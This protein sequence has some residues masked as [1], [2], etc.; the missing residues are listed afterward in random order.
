LKSSTTTTEKRRCDLQNARG[1]RALEANDMKFSRAG[2]A[3][4]IRLLHE[5][6][7]SR[8]MT[9]ETT[10][11]CG[12]HPS[13][14]REDSIMINFGLIGAVA[15]AFLATT[16]AMAV[17]VRHHHRYAYARRVAPVQDPQQSWLG[18]ADRAYEYYGIDKYYPEENYDADFDRKNTFN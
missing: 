11:D 7:T 6:S 10:F 18:P 2:E 3:A 16:P 8:Q 5:T 1:S 13:Q 12:H 14:E 15:I 4:F 17:Q 9:Q